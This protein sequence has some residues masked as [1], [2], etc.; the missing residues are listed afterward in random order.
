MSDFL[1]DNNIIINILKKA[2]FP[3]ST[4]IL[5]LKSRCWGKTCFEVVRTG[6]WKKGQTIAFRPFQ[7]LLISRLR[8]LYIECI[9]E[10][11]LIVV[12]LLRK[13]CTFFL[14]FE[15]SKTIVGLLTFPDATYLLPQVTLH[16]LYKDTLL[17]KLRKYF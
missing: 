13:N 11:F 12:L 6:K 15:S 3:T 14:Y 17:Q 16:I 5:L 7:T 2:F 9:N 8:L 4:S 10:C 1:I